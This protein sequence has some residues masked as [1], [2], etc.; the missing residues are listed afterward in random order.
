MAIPK[1]RMAFGKASDEIGTEPPIGRATSFGVTAA[2]QSGS[3]REESSSPICGPGRQARAAKTA[4]R[5]S[6]S[7]LRYWAEEPDHRPRWLLRA[8]RERPRC[9][10]AAEQRDE[11]ASSHVV[12]S[13]RGSHPTISLETITAFWPPDI[14]NGSWPCV[15]A[16]ALVSASPSMSRP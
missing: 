8:R 4:P 1:A 7:L 3:S 15:R 12:P 2:A 16:A 9:R 5:R 6:S 14:R 11:I 13:S 10:R